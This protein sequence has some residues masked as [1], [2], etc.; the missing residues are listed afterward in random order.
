MSIEEFANEKLG[1]D[2]HEDLTEEH[3]DEIYEQYELYL[4][5]TK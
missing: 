1:I 3:L 4:K 2:L 5:E